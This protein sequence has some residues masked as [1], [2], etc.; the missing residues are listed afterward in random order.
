MIRQFKTA[1]RLDPSL[2]PIL[3]YAPFA[4]RRR[5]AVLVWPLEAPMMD[6]SVHRLFREVRIES[7]LPPGSESH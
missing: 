7:G 3:D 1:A 2:H 5:D 6:A 4:P